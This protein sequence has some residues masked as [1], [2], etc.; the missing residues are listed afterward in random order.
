MSRVSANY[1]VVGLVA[2]VAGV[3]VASSLDGGGLVVPPPGPVTAAP[4][5][6]SRAGPGIGAHVI[7]LSRVGHSAIFPRVVTGPEGIV[8][9]LWQR[10]DGRSLVLQSAQRAPGGAWSSP[11]DVSHQTTD[12]GPAELVVGG[13]GV[14]TAV[15]AAPALTVA[16]RRPGAVAW[17]APR[18]VAAIGSASDFVVSATESGRV[19][20][21]WRDASAVRPR[22]E[23]ATLPA[24]GDQWI[25]SSVSSLPFSDSPTQLLI[26]STGRDSVEV[27]WQDNRDGACL[28]AA[29]A[30]ATNG[31][32]WVVRHRPSV[33]GTA[34]CDDAAFATDGH[35]RGI[36]VTVAQGAT[37]T[38]RVAA[39]WRTPSSVVTL[40]GGNLTALAGAAVGRD[41][42]ADVVV[43]ADFLVEAVSRSSAGAWSDLTPL[44]PAQEA[45]ASDNPSLFPQLARAGDGSAIVA[46]MARDGAHEPVVRITTRSGARGAWTPP[47][48]IRSPSGLRETRVT[49]TLDGRSA[50][51]VWQ[52]AASPGLSGLIDDQAG[53]IRAL[54]VRIPAP[55]TGS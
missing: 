55:A 9:A 53:T 37:G 27:A 17:S 40:A 42:A 43:E 21:V 16:R 35:G 41:G 49:I 7:E 4:T 36:V 11:V 23:A 26:A 29:S 24:G 19:T 14:V 5:T 48:S 8:T 54:T 51:L 45:P 46:W 32:R 25:R 18:A 28:G 38:V 44:A 2:L 39:G 15:W 52:T 22:V 12:A 1:L 47:V 34:S 3:A 30:T 50:T 13:D 20:I 10:T 33:H 31:L 6:L